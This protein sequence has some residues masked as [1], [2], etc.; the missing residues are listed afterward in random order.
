MNGQA[1]ER[2]DAVVDLVISKQMTNSIPAITYTSSA[3]NPSIVDDCAFRIGQL[4][5]NEFL[6]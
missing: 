5:G 3:R 2:H 1:L 4:D 6:D